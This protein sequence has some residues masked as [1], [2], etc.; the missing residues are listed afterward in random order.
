MNLADKILKLR[1]ENGWSQEELADKCNVSR[2]SVSKWEGGLS[3]PDL[4][5][6]IMMSQMFGVTTDY[7]LK[8]EVEQEEYIKKDEPANGVRRVSLTEANEFMNLKE[9]DAKR[10]AI[11]VMLCILSPIC[12][13]LL[14]GLS[15]TSYVNMT[16]DVAGGIGVI[17][18]LMFVAIATAI[19][20]MEGHRLKGYE[21]LEKESFELEYGVYGVVTER[22]KNYEKLY[23]WKLI[24]GIVLCIMSPF[25]LFA[26]MIVHPIDFY[27]VMAVD[28]L[29]ILVAIGVFLIVSCEIIKGSFEQ[30]LQEGDYTVENKSAEKLI[31]VIGGI[32][33][34]IVVAIYLGYS[35][36]TMNWGRS[37]IIWP[38]AGVLFGA[39]A[40]VCKVVQKK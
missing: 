40:G 16:E 3:I 15:E 4:D 21:F 30:L 14:G 11:G 9:I 32:Y 1:K 28:A 29:L 26:V 10:I 25:P 35:F 20:I 5:K 38:V 31:D 12:L 2:Q 13:L 8:D 37:W 27:F 39:V 6:I 19:F 34:P 36:V 18:L 23:N 22:K 33:W 17:V 7:L 24:V